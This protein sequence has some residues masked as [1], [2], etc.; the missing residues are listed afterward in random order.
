MLKDKTQAFKVTSPLPL[1]V[2][3]LIKAS[4]V[5]TGNSAFIPHFSYSGIK[6][7]SGVNAEDFNP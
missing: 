4:Y 7:K 6:D 2:I 3:H 5:R 1:S